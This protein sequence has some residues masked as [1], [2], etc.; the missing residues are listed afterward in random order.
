[1]VFLLNIRFDSVFNAFIDLSVLSLDCTVDATEV[2]VR[3]V[4]STVPRSVFLL[5]LI[6]EY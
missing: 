1:M 3:S 4:Q 5:D 2:V 6:E